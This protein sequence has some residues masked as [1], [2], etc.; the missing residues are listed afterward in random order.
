MVY[1]QYIKG[2]CGNVRGI[3]VP[4]DPLTITFHAGVPI[5]VNKEQKE[6]LDK[7]YKGF[8]E[9]VED[10]DVNKEIETTPQ[11]GIVK[12]KDRVI[13][14]DEA[15]AM[16]KDEQIKLLKKRGIDNIGKLEDER[17]DQIMES[18]PDTHPK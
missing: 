16:R 17:V 7:Y 12:D 9:E 6:F 4:L 1:V 2:V 8:F 15:F 11:Q 10:P 18:N 5:L 14:K 3:S 13:T